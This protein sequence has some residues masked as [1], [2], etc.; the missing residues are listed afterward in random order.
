[1]KSVFLILILFLGLGLFA[2]NFHVRTRLL[3]ITLIV[4]MILYITYA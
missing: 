1:M 3:L 4:G 2:R